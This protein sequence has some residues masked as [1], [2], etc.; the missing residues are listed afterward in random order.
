MAD[1][2][3]SGADV[4]MADLGSPPDAVKGREQGFPRPVVVIQVFK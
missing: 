1:F 2:D 4:V 3:F